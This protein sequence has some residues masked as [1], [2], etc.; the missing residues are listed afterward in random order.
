MVIHVKRLNE[1]ARLPKYAYEDDAG[2]DLFSVEEL[3]LK[4]GDIKLCRTGIALSIPVGYVGLI[5]DKSGIALKGGIKT[6][7]GVIDSGYRGEVGVILNNLSKKEYIIKEGDKVAQILFQ[8]VEHFEIKEVKTLTNTK[9][10]TGG[11]GSTKIR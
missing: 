4:P 5:W 10:D 7:G 11:F 3:I 1:K 2:M 6:M 9:R 8:R